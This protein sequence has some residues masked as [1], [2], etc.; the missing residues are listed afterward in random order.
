MT[1]AEIM[2]QAKALSLQERKE[3]VSY[4]ILK[5][6]GFTLARQPKPPP[7]SAARLQAPGEQ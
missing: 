2:E 3:L 1:V 6:L 5:G 7:S 4:P